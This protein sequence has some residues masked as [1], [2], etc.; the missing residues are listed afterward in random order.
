MGKERTYR[1]NIFSAWEVAWGL[2]VGIITL[3]AAYRIPTD[4]VLGVEQGFSIKILEVVVLVAFL[5]DPLL[6]LRSSLNRGREA[7]QNFLKYLLPVDIIA[8]IGVS[9]FDQ[10]D[11]LQLL[12]LLKLI[13]V[14]V[15]ASMWRHQLLKRG[16]VVRLALFSYWLA[17]LV[18]ITACGWIEM[19]FSKP[20]VD[21]D[22]AYLESVYWSVT[23]LTTIGYGDITPRNGDQMKYTIIIELVGFIMMGYLIGNIAG[24]LNKP[25]PLRAQYASA[26]EEVSAFVQYHSLPAD[27]K[28]RIVDYFG[29]MW[30]QRA[31]FNES[32]ILDLLPGGI[33]TEVSLHLKR[34]VIQR[35]P[36]F[37]EASE[38]FIREIANE[39]RPL[40]VTPG[41]YVFHSGDPAVNMYFISRGNLEVLDSG[42]Q[43]I[44]SLSD[45]DFFGE[46]ALLEKRRRMGSIRALGY[47]DLYELSFD[48]F[49]RIVDVHP[50]FKFYMQDIARRRAEAAMGGDQGTIR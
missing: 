26:L 10:G 43:V 33:K 31:A 27:L 13:N 5:L 12:A 1:R 28:H 14:T 7:R 19:R 40:V 20:I 8:A 35:V 36:F 3:Y 4:L 11:W 29:Y 9:V 38:T 37:R 23:T 48:A 18:H 6:T 41:E 25:D 45:G 50:D 16:N 15:F 44:G 46:M 17:V 42:G 49:N 32:S 34:D 24:L 30:Q 22:S 2:F 39:M 21:H 47:C